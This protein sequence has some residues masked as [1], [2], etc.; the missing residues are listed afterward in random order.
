MAEK[1]QEDAMACS[2]TNL[3]LALLTLAIIGGLALQ[4]G[5][6]HRLAD[7]ECIGCETATGARR[8]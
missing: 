8:I 2:G 5:A 7:H 3:Q 1:G 6:D 4:H